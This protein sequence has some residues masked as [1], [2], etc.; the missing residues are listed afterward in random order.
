MH[1]RTA[2]GM[3]VGWAWWRT[4]DEALVKFFGLGSV[5]HMHIKQAKKGLELER[6]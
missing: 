6:L 1:S 5:G 4:A 3:H 2:R